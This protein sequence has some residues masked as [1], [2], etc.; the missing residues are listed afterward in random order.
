MFFEYVMKR[1]DYIFVSSF[2]EVWDAFYEFTHIVS[3]QTLIR[4]VLLTICDDSY[5]NSGSL[6]KK[7]K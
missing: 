4:M 1:V 5:E 6:D 3:P 2:A 7:C